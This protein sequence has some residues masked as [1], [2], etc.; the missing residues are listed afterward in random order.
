[1]HDGEGRLNTA[2]LTE[3]DRGVLGAVFTKDGRR[4]LTWSELTARVW[5]VDAD[6]KA[7]L[8]SFEHKGGVN[9]VVFNTDGSRSLTWSRD[10]GSGTVKFWA[11]DAGSE[12]LLQSIPH[13][14]EIKDAVFSQDG[15][16]VLTWSGD[17]TAQ[18]WAVGPGNENPIWSFPLNANVKGAVFSEDSSR[19]LTW[20][21]DGTARLWSI[22]AKPP[23]PASQ[24]IL[25]MEVLTATTPYG[26][27]TM[28]A[29]SLDEWKTKTRALDALRAKRQP[30]LLE[31]CGK[32]ALRA[33]QQ[34]LK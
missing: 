18:L 5:V 26:L 6:N 4:L 32:S 10:G 30:T 7:P 3:A 8:Q 24:R 16:R 15:R 28:R 9:R 13:K 17:G 2:V 23:M 11:V 27:G 19:V 14:A 20:S 29:L 33:W 12:K 1:M 22:S 34:M 21:D 31:L 25:E